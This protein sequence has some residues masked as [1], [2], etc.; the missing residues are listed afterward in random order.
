MTVYLSKYFFVTD[1]QMNS[2]NTTIA[3]LPGYFS[4]RSHTMFLPPIEISKQEAIKMID[5]GVVLFT[6]NERFQREVFE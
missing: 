1:V 5:S 6:N 3:S 4:D 2:D